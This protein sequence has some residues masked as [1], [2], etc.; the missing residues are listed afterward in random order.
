[1]KLTK[2]AEINEIELYGPKDHKTRAVFLTGNKIDNL[3]ARL[4]EERT[5]QNLKWKSRC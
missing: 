2:R 1:M 4:Q 5:I 3:L